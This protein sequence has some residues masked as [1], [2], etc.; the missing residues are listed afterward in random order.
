MFCLTKLFRLNSLFCF[1]GVSS[2]RIC[3]L[4]DGDDDNTGGDIVLFQCAEKFSKAQQ[5]R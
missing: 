3:L 1:S 5:M 2:A 4:S